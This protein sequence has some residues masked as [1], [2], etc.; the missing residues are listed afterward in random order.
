[1]GTIAI[2]ITHLFPIGLF[3]LFGYLILK[4]KVY[5]L[6]SGFELKTE[7]EKQQLIE[8]GYPE[9]IGR[10][11]IY[12]SIIL[13][14]G[15]LLF[16]L[17]IPHAI[18]ISWLVLIVYM[19]GALIYYNKLDTTKSRKRDQWILIGTFL[20]TIIILTGAGYAG[21][22]KNEITVTENELKIS[23]FYGV[24]WP[25]AELTK[26]ELVEEIPEVEWRTNGFALGNRLKGNF[27]LEGLGGGKLFLY[28]N[29]PPFLYIEK[30]DDFVF[31][32]DK[33]SEV[34]KRWFREIEAK[35]Q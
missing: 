30:G 23:G 35:R 7:E 25:L 2:V 16:L 19:F 20:L 21:F 14:V 6:I 5:S 33:D 34:T 8:S 13:A 1:M 26:V 11:M 10:V 15:L 32:N 29:K 24:E 22:Q 27:R 31:I 28:V 18:E 12:S 4:K 3:L 17:E 9:A